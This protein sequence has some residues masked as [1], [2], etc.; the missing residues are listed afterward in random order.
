MFLIKSDS[1]KYDKPQKTN[2][3]YVRASSSPVWANCK[4]SLTIQDD[5]FSSFHAEK[6]KKL[7]DIALSF[8]EKKF[9][10]KDLPLIEDL[11]N[12]E[13]KLLK[14]YAN[15]C[16]SKT[17]LKKKDEFFYGAEFE[18]SSNLASWL[19]RGFVDFATF[20]G[21][22][23][24]VIDLKTGFTPLTEDYLI[25]LKI[26]CFLIMD[27]FHI[28]P[29]NFEIYL[30]TRLGVID[31][32]YDLRAMLDEKNNLVNALNKD[33]FDFKLGEHCKRCFKISKCKAAQTYVNS[34]VLSKNEVSV[35][36]MLLFE[37]LFKKKMEE[38]KAKLVLDFVKGRKTPDGVY[39]KHGN[40]YKY[41]KSEEEVIDKYGEKI[42]QK[43]LKSPAQALKESID[44]K[45]E[46]EKL[47][48]LTEPKIVVTTTKPK[49]EIERVTYK[50]L[51]EEELKQIT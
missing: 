9:K 27:C 25:Q 36:K 11:T 30:F 46:I 31:G 45:E 24:K 16:F 35:Q 18:V 14:D 8:L 33:G 1:I 17:N 5:E 26:Y 41:W 44:S 4:G 13:N 50:D 32:Y 3:T 49:K 42:I 19:L 39:F 34:I 28:N 51:M 6:G 22:T 7:H 38:I 10:K 37:T 20:D 40:K 47:Y 29:E 12:E 2:K 21:K 48:G 43:K 23:L 15:F